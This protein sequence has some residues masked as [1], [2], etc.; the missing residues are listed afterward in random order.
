MFSKNQTKIT[1]S[2][3]IESVRNNNNN[4]LGHIHV[5]KVEYFSKSDYENFLSEHPG[6]ENSDSFATYYAHLDGS[7]DD[8]Y[9]C[10]QP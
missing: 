5:E 1:S 6:I 9:C 8:E 7:G 3:L 2:T 10:A 4:H